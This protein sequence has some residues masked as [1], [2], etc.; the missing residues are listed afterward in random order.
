[1]PIGKKPGDSDWYGSNGIVTISGGNWTN[2]GSLTVGRDGIGAL[3]VSGGNVSSA[4]A[5]IGTDS[6]ATISGGNWTNTGSLTVSNPNSKLTIN[7]GL[8]TVGGTIS[9]GA[10]GNISLNAGGTL[11]FVGADGK[12]A[13][14]LAYNGTLVFNNTIDY[15]YESILSGSGSLIKEGGTTLTFKKTE[16][17]HRKY[18]HQCRRA[19]FLY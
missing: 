12:L 13:H 16:R 15:S 3:T 4:S 18:H 17:L 5:I 8:L 2:S 1:M 14:D 10:A 11:S 19:V 7:G 6:T 9:R